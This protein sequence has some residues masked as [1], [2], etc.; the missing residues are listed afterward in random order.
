MRARGA[1]VHECRR[2]RAPSLSEL[3]ESADLRR[4][5]EWDNVHVGDSGSASLELVLDLVLLLVKL[6]LAKQ[7]VDRLVVLWA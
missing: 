6:A 4:G 7:V 1:L 5:R 2:D 3:E